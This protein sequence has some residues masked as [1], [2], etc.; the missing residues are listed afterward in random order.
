MPPFASPQSSPTPFQA[1]RTKRI[2]LIDDGD[3]VRSVVRTFLEEKGFNV[4]GEAA[5]GVEGIEQAKRLQPDLIVLDLAMPGMNGVEAASILSHS[6][7][8]VPI[9]LLTM[10]E[11]GKSLA[12]AAGIT[13]MVSKT[14]GLNTLVQHI[15]SCLPQH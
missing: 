14:D 1:V 12:S 13:A 15:N 9:I 11:L 3:E 7:P 8:G 2:L 5:N 10:Y 6:L 4:C